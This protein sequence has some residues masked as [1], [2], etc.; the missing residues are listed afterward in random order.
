MTAARHPAV[1]ATASEPCPF[2]GCGLALSGH[3]TPRRA[4]GHSG[5]VRYRGPA[6]TYDQLPAEWQ[7]VMRS[8]MV[9]REPTAAE[10]AALA[11]AGLT[12]PGH[13]STLRWFRRP[14]ALTHAELKAG[15]L[16]AYERERAELT[17]ETADAVGEMLL[18]QNVR[19]V[20]YRYPDDTADDLP[21]PSDT[22]WAHTYAFDMRARLW[23]LPAVVVLKTIDCYEYQSCEDDDWHVSEAY[24][25]CDALRHAAIHSIHGYDNANGWTFRRPVD[26]GAIV[27]TDLIPRSKR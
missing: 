24:Q 12:M 23:E 26:S 5:R 9:K 14:L 3:S 25:F 1:R 7:R 16:T 2:C 17:Y 13:G 8:R 22:E 10:L 27:L 4:R 18:R 11:T 20:R 21:G 15:G 19:S 6:L